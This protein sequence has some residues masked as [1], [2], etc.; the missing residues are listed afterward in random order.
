MAQEFPTGFGRPKEW[1]HFTKRHQL[2][3]KRFPNLQGAL[4]P[5]F[6]RGFSSSE[7]VDRVVFISGRLCVEDFN[8]IL[9]LCGNGHGI[10][11]MKILRGMYERAVTARYLHLYP[12]ET[13]AFLN[14]YWIS[15]HRLAEDFKRTFGEDF[16]PK[17]ELKKIEERY[18]EVR[19]QFMVTDCKKCKTKRLNHTWSKLDFISMARQVGGVGKLTLPAYSLPTQEAHST[20]RAILSRL[21][22]TQDGRLTFDEGP[23]H[24]EA[25]TCLIVAHSTILDVLALQ[26]EHFKLD[27]LEQPL[28]QCLQDFQEIWGEKRR[29]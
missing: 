2:F 28:Q 20:V 15:Q 22:E 24:D 1:K 23:K 18:Q 3:L 14:F 12:K 9:L 6:L 19:D 29:P 21:K 27:R 11:A 5:A 16:A 13:D 4:H 17:D 26:K 10:G 8:E 7:P 25:D